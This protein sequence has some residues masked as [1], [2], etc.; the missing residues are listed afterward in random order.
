MNLSTDEAHISLFAG[1]ITSSIIQT[2]QDLVSVELLVD[3]LS[4]EL[5]D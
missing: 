1:V 3:A 4:Q 2:G 5:A